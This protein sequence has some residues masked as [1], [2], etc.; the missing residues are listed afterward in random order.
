V[1]EPLDALAWDGAGQHLY[2]VARESGTIVVMQ[3]GQAAVRRLATVPKGSGRL[4][5]LC[6]DAQGGVWIALQDGWSVVRFST[7]GNQDRVIGLP[8]PSPTDL[9]FGG[10]AQDTLYVTSARQSVPVEALVT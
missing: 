1:G 4:G 8:V 10:S 2:G 6:V 5:G 3:P 7:D 9:A